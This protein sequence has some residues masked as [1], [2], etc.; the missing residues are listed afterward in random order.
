MALSNPHNFHDM[1]FTFLP[2][3]KRSAKAGRNALFT[4]TFYRHNDQWVFDD[5]RR[6][7]AVE[8]LVCGADDVFDVLSGRDQDPAI[9][10]CTVNFSATPIPGH[11][12]HASFQKPEYGGSVYTTTD[13]TGDA[14]FEFWLCPALFAYFD[15]APQD[16]YVQKVRSWSA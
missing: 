8:P 10:R 15:R 13:M 14:P 9:N 16:I 4:L 5:D 6:D 3:R 7:I 1:N 2:T 12:V 11:E